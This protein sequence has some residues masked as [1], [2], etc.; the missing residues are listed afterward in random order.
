M[1][2]LADIQKDDLNSI[3]GLNGTY[4][5]SGTNAVLVDCIGFRASVDTVISALSNAT[6]DLGIVTGYAGKTVL[7]GQDI[8]FGAVA[9]SITLTSGNGEAYRASPPVMP[10]NPVLAGYIATSVNGVTIELNFDQTM[11]NPAALAASFVVSVAGTPVNLTS[12]AL[13]GGDS[14]NIIITPVT[15]IANG[16]VVTITIAS[17]AIKSAA[18]AYFLGVTAGAVTNLVPA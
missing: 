16:D 8:W 13:K 5:V 9:T 3:A 6:H 18:G 4:P 2:S 14:T 10:D 1:K 15:P 12:V 11:A 7:A 17:K